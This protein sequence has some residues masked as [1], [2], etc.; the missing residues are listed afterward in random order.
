MDVWVGLASPDPTPPYVGA[1]LSAAGYARMPATF[2]PEAEPS[3]YLANIEAIEFNLAKADWGPVSAALIYDA[4]TGGTLLA[5]CPLVGSVGSGFG[6]GGWGLYGYATEQGIRVV[7]MYDRPRIEPGAL[8]WDGVHDTGRVFALQ[9][10]FGAEALCSAGTW[11]P[12]GPFAR[13]A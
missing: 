9:L 1:E 7:S 2:A 10:T 8:Q 6:M 3:L 13:A 11:S 5:F 4:P 12:P